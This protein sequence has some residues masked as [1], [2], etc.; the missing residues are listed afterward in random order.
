MREVGLKEVLL[1]LCLSSLIYCG[2]F[3]DYKTSDSAYALG[4]FFYFPFA[5]IYVPFL[6]AIVL[7]FCGAKFAL[8]LRVLFWSV[9][10]SGI[11]IILFQ[12]YTF[13]IIDYL[14]IPKTN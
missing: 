11:F 9:I 5:M 8:L 7:R 12:K 10:L 4:T 14:A 13:G 6:S 1:G 3:I 2:L